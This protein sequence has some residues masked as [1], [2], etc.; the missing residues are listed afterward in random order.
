MTATKEAHPTPGPNEGWSAPDISNGSPERFGYEWGR[1]SELLPIYEQMFLKWTAMLP[2]DF[3]KGKRFLDVGCGMGR[4]SYWPMSYGAQ[5]G[6]AIDVDD[7]SLAAAVKTLSK[8]PA[9]KVM[10]RSAYDIGY[11]NQFD[12]T[13]SIGVVQILEFPER[14]LAEMFRATKPG[15]NGLIW[16]YGREN[17]GWI[18]H[19]LSPLRR[20][21]L[22]RIPVAALHALS[23][24]PASVIWLGLRLGLLGSLE[25]FKMAR[26]FGFA[27]L[28]S[29]I[30]DQCLPRVAHYWTRAEVEAMMRAAGFA[31]IRLAWIN[32]MSW[33]AIGTKP[34]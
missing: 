32:E 24:L 28:R 15:G 27:H 17:N 4:N 33:T 20:H 1:Y 31:E 30:F 19:G 7:R 6:V 26:S 2:P 22:S 21:L 16:V 11:E 34:N 23:V 5:S 9:V 8:F 12:V 18:V 29:I 10:K 3:W 25:Y 14:A 13:F